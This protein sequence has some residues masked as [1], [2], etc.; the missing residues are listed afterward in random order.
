MQVI[1]LIEA[2]DHV[3]ARYRLQAFIPAL[4]RAGCTLVL[5]P[6]PRGALER[7]RLFSRLRR[8]DAVLLQRQLLPVPEYRYLRRMAR[9]LIYDFDDAMLYRDSYHPRGHSSV[10]RARRFSAIVRS[11]D[12]VIAGNAFLKD[13]AIESGARRA[14]VAVMPTCVEPERYPPRGASSRAQDLEMVWIGS[15]STL[16]GLE[17]QRPLLQRLG[18]EIPCLRLR[19]ICDRFVNFDPLPVIQVVWAEATEAASIAQADFGI[20]WM[21]DDAWSKGK[22]GLKVLQY[23]AARIPTIANPVGV[24]REIIADGV[25][26]L[27]AVTEDQWLEAVRT[28]TRD[29]VV[30]AAMGTQARLAVEQSYSVAAHAADFVSILTANK[31]VLRSARVSK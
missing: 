15:S 2:P 31:P 4:A 7:I 26:G 10:Q 24:H 18:R 12:T 25:T 17:R 11:A 16:A 28:L 29:P 22:C 5:E 23:G 14:D 30:R 13:C 8:F 1:A 6:I 19:L 3:S 9:R 27:L 20:S 21:P